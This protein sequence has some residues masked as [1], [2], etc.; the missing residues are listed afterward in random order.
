MTEHIQNEFLLLIIQIIVIMI[1]LWV[2]IF[3]LNRLLQ[4]ITKGVFPKIT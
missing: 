4:K 2:A 1:T 3:I